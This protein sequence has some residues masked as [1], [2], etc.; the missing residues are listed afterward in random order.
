MFQTLVGRG[1]AEFSTKKQQDAMEYLGHVLK[2]T[3]RNSNDDDPGQC[4]KFQ[5][6]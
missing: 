2:L 3:E 6:C 4:F 1:H 5:V